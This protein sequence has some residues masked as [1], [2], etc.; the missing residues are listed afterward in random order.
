MLTRDSWARNAINIWT[1][2]SIA[3]CPALCMTFVD[4]VVRRARTW[5]ARGMGVR[6]RGAFSRDQPHH[7]P[8]VPPIVL[9]GHWPSPIAFSDGTRGF[10]RSRSQH[11][12]VLT[13]MNAPHQIR[14][15]GFD[16]RRFAAD[17]GGVR[18][19]HV[20]HFHE[21]H[22]LR[23]NVHFGNGAFLTLPVAHGE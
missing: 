23:N 18:P 22:Y 4:H 5:T 15:G 21:L 14:M 20:S 3:A 9:S 16:S 12:I 17:R 10:K 13:A 11:E 7:G 1:R 6:R 19:K 2:R 8:A